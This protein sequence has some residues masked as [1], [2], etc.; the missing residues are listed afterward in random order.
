MCPIGC[1]TC[2]LDRNGR[3]ECTSCHPDYSL[4]V[5]ISKNHYCERNSILSICPNNYDFTQQTCSISNLNQTASLT[6]SRNTCFTQLPNCIVCVSGSSS[7]CSICGQNFYLFKG[8]CEAACPN[9]TTAYQFQRVCL[10]IQRSNCLAETTRSAFWL[11]A[12]NKLNQFA[13]GYFYL[14]SANFQANDYLNDPL[15]SIFTYLKSPDIQSRTK[16]VNIATSYQSCTHCELGYGLTRRGGCQKCLFP[17]LEC[18]YYSVLAP[19]CL[20]CDAEYRLTPNNTCAKLNITELPC[21]NG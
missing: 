18:V 11:F 19:F 14:I 12:K 13:D 8:K 20:R 5:T 6:P 3:L 21:K 17:C 2:V 15:G 16:L 9:A 1:L 7:E 4:F 10:P